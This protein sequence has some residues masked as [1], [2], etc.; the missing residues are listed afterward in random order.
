MT[1]RT[2]VYKR[3]ENVP[4]HYRKSLKGM[5][6]QYG[7]L[8]WLFFHC[9]WPEYVYTV[10]VTE[11]D[12]PVSWGILFTP[13]IR[14]YDYSLWPYECIQ[15]YTKFSHRR[16]GYGTKVY[17]KLASLRHTKEKPYIWKDPRVRCRNNNK[18]FFDSVGR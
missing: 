12:I 11:N 17:N 13:S 15:L 5:G 18:E 14:D 4:K 6:V 1:I 8:R 7:G 3:R 2:H 10:I 9:T 16:L